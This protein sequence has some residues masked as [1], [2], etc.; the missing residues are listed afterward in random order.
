MKTVVAFGY[1]DNALLVV[2]DYGTFRRVSLN[3]NGG[4]CS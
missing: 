3:L 1:H 2:N 4:K